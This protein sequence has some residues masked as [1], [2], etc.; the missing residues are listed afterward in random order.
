[1][2]LL[3][4]LA[5]VRYLCNI[6]SQ[7]VRRT[8]I[9][10]LEDAP[11]RYVGLAVYSFLHCMTEPLIPLL[12]EAL[13][14]YGGVQRSRSR[15]QRENATADLL[16]PERLEAAGRRHFL[17]FLFAASFES[18]P[19]ALPD[20]ADTRRSPSYLRPALSLLFP[21]RDAP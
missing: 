7:T 8:R 15:S 18:P 3:R 5:V 12:L 14:W 9:T 2:F 20:R 1:M 4:A 21:I 6:P 19:Q 10:S 11:R 16:N 17:S 13:D